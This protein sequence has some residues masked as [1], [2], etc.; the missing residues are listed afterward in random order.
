MAT[1]I[2][3]SFKDF[4]S[5]LEITNWQTGLVSDRRTNVISAIKKE[6][7]LL[8]GEESRL[9]GSYDRHT[10][11]RY[12]KE[13]DVD[14]MVVL[15]PGDNN[16]WFDL[17]GGAIKALDRF[18]S[19][20]TNAYPKTCI[21]RDQNCITMSFSEFRLDVVPAFKSNAGHYSIPDSVG[22][23]EWVSTDPLKF[24]EKI[25][26]ANNGKM[27]KTFVPLIKMV[28][29]WNRE[30]GHPIHSFHLECIMYNRYRSYTVSY[31]YASMLR[32]FFA[33]LPGYLAAACH[34]PIMNVRV[35]T[36][37]DNDAK[38]TLRET[39]IKKA[40][41]AAEESAIAYADQAKYSDCPE[42]PI[43]KWKLLLGQFFPTYG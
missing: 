34:D 7:T 31:T 25:T 26:E 12:L 15:N 37:L 6:L 39:A 38:V 23:I 28:K 43:T 33:D 1:T 24:A 29:A 14:V 30:V 32:C 20:L 18:R 27:N 9:I 3:Q 17:P 42:I 16:Q 35:D 21:R 41:T 36:Y 8:T 22:Q 13:G 4:S 40:T 10:M 11:I 5:N 19:I 2:V